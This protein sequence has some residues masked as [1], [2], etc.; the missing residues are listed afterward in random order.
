MSDK[1]IV[2]DVSKELTKAQAGI[3]TDGTDLSNS[4]TLAKLIDCLLYACVTDDIDKLSTKLGLPASLCHLDALAIWILNETQCVKFMDA[5]A[6]FNYLANQLD[7]LLQ[8]GSA[9]T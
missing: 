4:H 9:R 5:S 7:A 2:A 3:T 8:D 1:V 6:L